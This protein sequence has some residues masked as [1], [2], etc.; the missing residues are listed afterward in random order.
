MAIELNF[1]IKDPGIFWSLQAIDQLG[2]FSFSTEDITEV[3]DTYLDTRKRRLLAKG[4]NC[5]KRETGKIVTIILTKLGADDDNSSQPKVWKVKLKKNKSNPSDWPNSKVR[6]RVLKIIP[7]KKLQPIFSYHQTRISRIIK[8]DGQGV[9]HAYLDDISLILN[10]KELH[11]KMLELNRA[12][13]C[14]DKDLDTLIRALQAK[15]S[16]KPLAL[17]KFEYALALEKSKSR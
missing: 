10:K 5:C 9:T 11:F 3:T 17:T 16:L 14:K 7:E 15:W 8:R 1:R 4:Y 12:S 2:E 13:N 6:T